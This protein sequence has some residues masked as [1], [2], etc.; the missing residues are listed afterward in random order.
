[1]GTLGVPRGLHALDVAAQL[2]DAL[3]DAS[4]V[5][6]DLGLTGAAGADALT[7]GHPATRLTGPRLTPPAQSREQV[8]ELSQL[9]LGPTLTGLGVLGED[10]E[11]QRGAVD[12]LD[13]DDVLQ[14]PS[15]RRSEL[16]V[17]DDRVRAL[18]DH[19]VAQLL[20]LAAAEV[21]RRVGRLPT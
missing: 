2:G 18:R 4:P 10:V 3:V 6:L 14:R 21:C 5:Q 19:D 15:L 13:L 7:A 9:D 16:T 17:D 11:D 1:G 12:H 8:L 20:G